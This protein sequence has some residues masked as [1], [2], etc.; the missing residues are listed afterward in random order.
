MERARSSVV[1][2]YTMGLKS[3]AMHESFAL[4]SAQWSI[5]LLWNVFRC[6]CSLYTLKYIKDTAMD[7]WS[8]FLFKE[9]CN[10]REGKNCLGA[11]LYSGNWA[12]GA[13]PKVPLGLRPRSAC[14][15]KTTYSSFFL[16]TCV[17]KVSECRLLIV[18]ISLIGNWPWLGPRP[19][20]AWPKFP[21]CGKS[22][23]RILPHE[24]L[25]RLRVY[26]KWWQFDCL[27]QQEFH[28]SKHSSGN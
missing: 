13:S 11:L 3:L 7:T 19:R 2:Q 14:S 8:G 26:T 23:S 22:L 21:V 1:V 9:S 27:F 28:E 5:H 18:L 6:I 4:I 12:G 16:A 15:K 20:W 17:T 10:A 25:K 24:C